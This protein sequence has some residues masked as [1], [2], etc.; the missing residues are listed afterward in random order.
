MTLLLVQCQPPLCNR[1]I[2]L[3][4]CGLAHRVPCVAK[5][6]WYCAALH[7]LLM[8]F[9]ALKALRGL[10]LAA[11][12][13]KEHLSWLN[14]EEV[15]CFVRAHL[16]QS[17]QLALSTSA[18]V[19]KVQQNDFYLGMY[20]HHCLCHIR[21]RHVSTDGMHIRGAEQECQYLTKKHYISLWWEYKYA[22]AESFFT[23]N[24]WWNNEFKWSK[25]EN[26]PRRRLSQP[27]KA[28]IEQMIRNRCIINAYTSVCNTGS[29]AA[30]TKS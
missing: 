6:R 17:L 29:Y 13:R 16:P 7:S 23:E 21:C 19:V 12:V 14:M 18:V 28:E 22:E 11:H 1:F 30:C 26:I 4:P 24:N 20:D 8:L 25:M 9:V 27:M 2:F 3:F 15:V 5:T 10:E